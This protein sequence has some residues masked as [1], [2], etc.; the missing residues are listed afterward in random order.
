[1][2][3]ERTVLDTQDVKETV[4]CFTEMSKNSQS[5]YVQKSMPADIWVSHLFGGHLR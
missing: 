1:M 4:T 5:T 3:G 2:T